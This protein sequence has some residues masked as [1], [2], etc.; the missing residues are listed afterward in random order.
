MA[1]PMRFMLNRVLV[2]LRNRLDQKLHP[3]LEKREV[4]NEL[5]VRSQHRQGPLRR[6]EYKPLP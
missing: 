6:P 3:L 2:S 4:K 5:V 1:A